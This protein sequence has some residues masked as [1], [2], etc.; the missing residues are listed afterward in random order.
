[1]A[2]CFT[3]HGGTNDAPG[4]QRNMLTKAQ[5]NSAL[6]V[7]YSIDGDAETKAKPEAVMDS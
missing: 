3:Y 4:K 1:M 2:R 6:A 5:L 7:V